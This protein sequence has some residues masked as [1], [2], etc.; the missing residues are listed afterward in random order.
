VTLP[1]CLRHAHEQ[2]ALGRQLLADRA[3]GPGPSDPAPAPTMAGAT[4]LI[5]TAIGIRDMTKWNAE[6]R[7]ILGPKRSIFAAKCTA[8]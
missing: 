2:A 6:R 5:A 7:A 8:P 3:G 1:D 4:K